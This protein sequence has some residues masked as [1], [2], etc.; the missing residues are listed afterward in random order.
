MRKG[1]TPSRSRS[2]L[3]SRSLRATLPTACQLGSNP[4]PESPFPGI[5]IEGILHGNPANDLFRPDRDILARRNRH[6][7]SIRSELLDRY[8]IAVESPDL[9]DL[10]SRVNP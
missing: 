2:R 5:P 10:K 9:S 1:E 4:G 6:V 8:G 7:G 3:P